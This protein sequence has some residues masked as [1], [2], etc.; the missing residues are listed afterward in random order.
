M[1]MI[2]V[3]KSNVP[4]PLPHLLF[5]TTLKEFIHELLTAKEASALMAHSAPCFYQGGSPNQKG[6]RSH[7]LR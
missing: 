1:T 7:Y 2:N 4:E 3:E 5:I 6:L